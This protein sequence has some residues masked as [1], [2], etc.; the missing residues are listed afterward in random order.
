MGTPF[1][2]TVTRG[3]REVLPRH[4]SILERFHEI[5]FQKFS[6]EA[7]GSSERRVPDSKFSSS[8]EMRAGQGG[9]SNSKFQIPEG[10]SSGDKARRKIEVSF[11]SVKGGP[12]VPEEVNSEGKFS[13]SLI[14]TVPAVGYYLL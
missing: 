9:E 14:R 4:H 1:S 13:S 3:N 8:R 7:L 11:S 5:G 2:R 12:L 10:P 6:G